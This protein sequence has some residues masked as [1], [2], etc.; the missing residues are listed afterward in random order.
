MSAKKVRSSSKR[1]SVEPDPLSS[2][3]FEFHYGEETDKYIEDFE[4]K[5][6]ELLSGQLDDL[7]HAE[8]KAIYDMIEEIRNRT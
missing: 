2:F 3:T 5:K 4:R 1:K 7:S 8:L 6:V